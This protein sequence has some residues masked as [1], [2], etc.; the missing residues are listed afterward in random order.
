MGK[1][2]P[3][4][5]LNFVCGGGYKNCPKAEPYRSKFIYSYIR[6][7]EDVLNITLRVV[8]GD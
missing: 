4:Y 3:I 8:K 6:T 1:A 2:I 5:P 7:S